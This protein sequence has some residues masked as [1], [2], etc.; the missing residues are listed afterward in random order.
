MFKVNNKNTRTTLLTLWWG[1][2][3]I[4]TFICFYHFIRVLK[5]SSDIFPAFAAAMLIKSS[6]ASFFVWFVQ[7]YSAILR[8]LSWLLIRSNIT[9]IIVV[10]AIIMADMKTDR[11]LTYLVNNTSFQLHKFLVGKY[12]FLNLHQCTCMQVSNCL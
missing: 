11:K 12:F 1:I 5:V 7:I 4:K 8:E 6:S 2:L 3:D 10:K 9:T